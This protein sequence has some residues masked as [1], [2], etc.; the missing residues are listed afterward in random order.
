ME[1]SR[2]LSRKQVFSLVLVIFAMF[3][4]ADGI[5]AHITISPTNSDGYHV[6]WYDSHVNARKLAGL[7]KGDYIVFQVYTRLRPNCWPCRVVKRIACDEGDR[8]EAENREF[9]CNGKLLGHSKTH[10]KKGVPV[11]SFE[12]N[13][14]IPKGEAFVMG[15]C[16]DSYD[17]RYFGLV[18][19]D[20]VEAIAH[21]IF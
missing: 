7:H 3:M 16:I 10:S 13:G 4:A 14:I 20:R 18:R 2:K 8:L 21:P 6:F 9:W 1:G 17:S 15:S 11:K 5:L 19:K 12:Y